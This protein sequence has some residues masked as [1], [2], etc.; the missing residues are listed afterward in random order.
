MV[1]TQPIN[2]DLVVSK[3]TASL[4]CQVPVNVGQGISLTRG[5]EYAFTLQNIAVDKRS[6]FD[7]DTKQE[8]IAI[9]GMA[10]NMPGAPSVDRIWG[11]LANG[12]NAVEE[13]RFG[14]ILSLSLADLTDS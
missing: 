1:L 11:I 4:P 9:V 2:W 7:F 12:S 6:D 3:V 13:V 14:C 8:P 10:V 5:T